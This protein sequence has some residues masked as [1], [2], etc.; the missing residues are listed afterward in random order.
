MAMCRSARHV[1]RVLGQFVGDV[2]PW[3]FEGD[4]DVRGGAQGGGV[5]KRTERDVD[6]GAVAHSE[7]SS[8]PQRA[9]RVSLAP[10]CPITSSSSAPV[11]SRS[12]SLGFRRRP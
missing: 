11:L 8:E 4:H 12:G 10:G 7:N 2:E 1:A 5:A 6:V 3:G 9:Q